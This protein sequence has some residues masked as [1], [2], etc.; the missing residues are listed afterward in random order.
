VHVIQ[1]INP[2]EIQRTPNGTYQCVIQGLMIK[3]SESDCAALQTG[4]LQ[5]LATPWPH[6][7]NI[8]V[9]LNTVTSIIADLTR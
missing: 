2:K 8:Q 7:D 1:N 3:L 4:L 9:E 5:K 6:Q